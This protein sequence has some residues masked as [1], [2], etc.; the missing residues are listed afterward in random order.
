M[1][2]ESSRRDRPEAPLLVGLILQ[3]GLL[4]TVVAA[5]LASHSRLFIFDAESRHGQY[6][7]LHEASSNREFAYQVTDN[8]FTPTAVLA[9][10]SLTVLSQTAAGIVFELLSAVS[11]IAACW[12]AYRALL[13]G[14]ETAESSRRSRIVRAVLFGLAAILSAP[15]LATLNAG[16]VDG[17]TMLLIAVA[18][19]LSISARTPESGDAVPERRKN[20]DLLAG[21]ALAVATG[22]NPF[23]IVLLVPILLL[24]RFR[25][26]AGCCAGLVLVFAVSPRMWLD[27]GNVYLSS[28]E[29][30]YKANNN[31]SITSALHLLSHGE[32][33]V[34]PYPPPP[35][36]TAIAGAMLLL[37]LNLFVDLKSGAPAE[38]RAQATL[39]LT[40]LPFA[41]I[42]PLTI[43]PH[44]LSLNLLL[45]P[46]LAYC[47]ITATHRLARSGIVVSVMGW[48]LTQSHLTSLE[49]IHNSLFPFAIAGIGTLVLM[50]GLLL[51]K[52]GVFAARAA[53]DTPVQFCRQ[54]LIAAPHQ[55]GLHWGV[56]SLLMCFVCV[57]Y[58]RVGNQPCVVA[59]WLAAMAVLY[60]GLLPLTE[61]GRN[62]RFSMRDIFIGLCLILTFAPA[63]L[64]ALHDYPVQVNTDELI[65]LDVMHRL[66]D[67]P[68]D[69][70]GVDPA[71]FHF[72]N[73]SFMLIGSLSRVLGG[74]SL[75]HVREVNACFGLCCVIA[76]YAFFRL[77]F[78]WKLAIAGAVMLGA[79]HVL[80]GLSRMAIRDNL[81]LLLELIAMSLFI[82]AWRRKN[83]SVM[84]LG[85]I[86]AGLGVYNYYS[87][88]I[89]LLV[90][91]GFLGIHLLARWSRENFWRTVKMAAVSVAGF[92]ICSAPM[93]IVASHAPPVSLEYPRQQVVLF[94][95][96]RQLVRDWEDTPDTR[97]A[98]ARNLGKGLTMFN[99]NLYDHS[100]I[101]HNPGYGIVDPLTGV[102]LWLG[103]FR[104]W[105]AGGNGRKARNSSRDLF[106]LCGLI[107]IWLPLSILLTKNPAF[108]RTLVVLP[109]VVI[110]ALDG[111]R[112]GV[113]T[114]TRLTFANPRW[115]LRW[116]M[117]A[118]VVLIVCAWNAWAYTA[119]I[120]RGIAKGDVPGNSMRYAEALRT[121]PDHSFYVVM[122][123]RYP[124]Y[125]FGKTMWKT[126]IRLFVS[127]DQKVD[128]LE[129][130]QLIQNPD[131]LQLLNR[132]C[133]IFIS[134][135][136][137]KKC[138]N[139]LRESFPDIKITKMTT[140]G[141]QLVLEL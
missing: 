72:P 84:L 112:F 107:L 53:C 102:L 134:G 79:S 32:A 140:D 41:L 61:E 8:H 119:H 28:D 88:R 26:V 114:L 43:D 68:H 12:L 59:A 48:A 81:P 5:A 16:T 22:L 117:L 86:V 33:G 31:A 124:Y 64:L 95:E 55:R 34:F 121:V 73:G 118:A 9:N 17:F 7:V 50:S 116:R 101:Y 77:F 70:F 45:L 91:I 135:K 141:A 131:E 106:I 138:G 36:L 19:F 76:G 108:S 25:I 67:K 38:P 80:L 54:F 94:P 90:W 125:S 105:R 39:L 103:L 75:E 126:W 115:R 27:Y 58:A 65:A 10:A 97:L 23:C 122:D 132:P 42:G 62:T 93:M 109:F 83:L 127:E 128:L 113:W 24:K 133:S 46:A 3:A 44:S 4:A 29:F 56:A 6:A 110:L 92:V 2:S 49:Q 89:I 30:L 57:V 69:W 82:T 13:A 96:G 100:Y 21:L 37:V 47:W 18:V 35:F 104:M 129:S 11:M 137:F 1:T 15:V 123:E 130:S 51:Y 40:Y 139:K 99:N 14:S 63:Y 87:A 120:Q 71:Y 74:I 111:A 66:L 78:R 98:L 20:L 60:L 136:L 52:L 85:G